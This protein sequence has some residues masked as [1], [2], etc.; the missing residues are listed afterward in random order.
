MSYGLNA[1]VLGL[2]CASQYPP[3]PQSHVTSHLL[4]NSLGLSVP[5]Q[6]WALHPGHTPSMPAG[7]LLHASG[8]LCAVC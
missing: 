5:L 2:L 3:A 1:E 4:D 6:S 7:G 8:V